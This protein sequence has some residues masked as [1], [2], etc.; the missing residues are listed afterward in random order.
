MFTWIQINSFASYPVIVLK[1]INFIPWGNF[2][3]QLL[4]VPFWIAAS[5]I[6]SNT[7]LL[8]LTDENVKTLGTDHKWKK[9]IC[10]RENL[11]KKNSCKVLPASKL[12]ILYGER[13]EPR[14]NARASGEAERSVLLLRDFSRDLSRLPQMVNCSQANRRKVYY[15]LP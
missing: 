4:Q 9:N 2:D 6:V 11:M 7:D 5:V 8:Q 3:T 13:S 15:H 1:N 12:S 14:K 10:A